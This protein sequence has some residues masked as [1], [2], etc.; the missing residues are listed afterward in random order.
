MIKTV[1]VTVQDRKGKLHY[2]R[3][4]P[5]FLLLEDDETIVS[6]KAAGEFPIIDLLSHADRIKLYIFRKSLTGVAVRR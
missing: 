4:R 5:A 1:Y 3:E 6:V 2:H